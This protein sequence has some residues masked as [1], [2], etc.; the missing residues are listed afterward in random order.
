MR[1]LAGV[2]T[3]SANLIV[4]A[5]L[6]K[7]AIPAFDIHLLDNHEVRATILG[8]LTM[9]GGQE[10]LFRRARTYWVVSLKKPLP[11]ELSKAFNLK[12]FFHLA[13]V[14]GYAGGKELASHGASSYYVD[15]QE[16]LNALVMVLKFEFGQQTHVR[17]QPGDFS[18]F[19][20]MEIQGLARVLSARRNLSEREIARM[21]IAGLLGL[22][23]VPGL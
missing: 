4:E 18:T 14:D 11:E 22:S 20:A 9:D 15:S 5:E 16:G 19:I 21:E 2:E 23:S 8:A 10:V 6:A 1:N 7:S 12:W 17:S 3:T 13:Q